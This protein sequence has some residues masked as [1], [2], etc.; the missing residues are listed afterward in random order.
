MRKWI[1][2]LLACLLLPLPVRG[3]DPELS[4]IAPAEP[5]IPWETAL[6]RYTLPEAGTVQLTLTDGEGREIMPVARDVQGVAGKNTLFWNGTWERESAPAGVWRLRLDAGD[7]H[8]ETE[9]VIAGEAPAVAARP[10]ESLEPLRLSFTPATT[11][12]WNGRDASLNYWTLP[13]DI[14]EEERI[15]QVLT[16]P[17]TVINIGKNSTEKTQVTIRKE[18]S[19][20]SEGVG[21]VTCETQGVHVLERGEEW[22]LIECYSSSFHDSKILNWN[23]LVQGYIL[24]KYLKEEIPNQEMGMVIDKLTQRLYLFREGRLY[25]TLLVSTGLSNKRQPYNETRSGEFLLTSKVGDFKSDNL[26]C[27]K[28]I[29]FNDGDLLHEVPYVLAADGVSRIYDTCEPKLGTKA[30]HGC[31]R[32]QRKKTPEGVNMYWIW[33]SLKKNS[34]TRLL[35]WEDWQGRQIEIPAEDTPLYWSARE[36]TYYHSAERCSGV[37]EG[38]VLARFPYGEL[39]TGAYA[40]LKP[41]P[42]CAPVLRR[43]EIEEINAKYAFGGDHDPVLTEARKSCPRPLK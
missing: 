24:T 33:D 21:V 19:A 11:S 5:L 12:P 14:H 4:V 29:R 39:E 10:A 38:L 26:T 31:I 9:I 37:K 43:A 1:C 8:A 22:S 15:W 28:A 25:S 42:Y 13:M 35:I 36:G 3:A 23:V 17:I 2:L 30:S 40:K 41:C 7:A 34:K 27:A 20:D 32:V 6:I 18:P 16:A